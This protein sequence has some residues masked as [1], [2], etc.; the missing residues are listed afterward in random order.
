[1]SD[2][3]IPQKSQSVS[4][5]VVSGFVAT[6]WNCSISAQNVERQF[7]YRVDS[8]PISAA[9]HSHIERGVGWVWEWKWELF[10]SLLARYHMVEIVVDKDKESH[11]AV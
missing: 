8:I 6:P 3:D 7:P 5:L 1:M 11:D 4:R 9:F 10:D 2:N